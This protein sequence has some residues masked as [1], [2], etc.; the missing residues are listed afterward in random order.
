MFAKEDVGE[1]RGLVVYNGSASRISKI[2][3]EIYHVYECD[4]GEGLPYAPVDFPNAGDKWGWMAGKRVTS[5]GTF[6]D[7]YLYSPK[8]F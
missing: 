7:R 5:S 4:S 1:S 6:R 2:G 8:H 3:L